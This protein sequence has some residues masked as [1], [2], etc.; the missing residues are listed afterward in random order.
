[1]R[2]WPPL[3]HFNIAFA[4]AAAVFLLGTLDWRFRVLLAVVGVLSYTLG[5]KLLAQVDAGEPGA[6][7][8]WVGTYFFVAG[9]VFG[10]GGVFTAFQIIGVAPPPPG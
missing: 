2:R 6:W 9:L 3:Q 8:K 5:Q 7:R 10:V 1:M 4:A